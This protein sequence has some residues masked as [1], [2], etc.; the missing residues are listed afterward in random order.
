MEA[1]SPK[2]IESV[3]AL[4]TSTPNQLA[5]TIS[6]VKSKVCLNYKFIAVL[7]LWCCLF[8]IAPADQDWTARL[9]LFIYLTF[10]VMDRE[11]IT[12]LGIS[13]CC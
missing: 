9:P 8:L 11:K 3:S 1:N 13:F 10:P 5:L 4:K 7:S 2:K 6:S 12:F